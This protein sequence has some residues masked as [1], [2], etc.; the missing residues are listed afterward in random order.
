[1]ADKMNPTV[2]D[3]R[4]Y[5]KVVV[6]TPCLSIGGTEIHTLSLARALI[7]EGCRVTICCYY[8]YDPIMLS[9][10]KAT[11]AEVVLMELKRSDGLLHLSKNLIALFHQIEP[12][13]V[14]IQYI[15]PALTPILAARIAGVK[16]VFATVHSSGS[17]AYGIKAR[18]MLRTAAIFCNAFFCPS[19]DTER[20]WFGNINAADPV[21]AAP[22]S[23]HYTIY[24]PIDT[25][26]ISDIIIKTDTGRLRAL[27]NIFGNPVIGIVG[28]FV[29]QK[30]HTVMLDVMA[31]VLKQI[32]G[33]LL[34]IIGDGP[35]H[36]SLK[37]KAH[38]L[39]I[40][41]NIRWAGCLSQDNL[42]SYYSIMNVVVMPSLYEGFG[43]VAAEAMAAGLP[44][45]GTRVDGLAEVIEDGVTGV[46]VDCGDVHSISKAIIEIV[47]DPKR[48]GAMGSRGRER[49]KRLYS[50]E[51]FATKQVYL[52]HLFDR[53]KE[54]RSH[55]VPDREIRL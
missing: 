27:L 12:D 19:R 16:T 8:E 34:L 35:E 31:E 24:D 15:A 5:E 52:Y 54:I 11:G 40:E 51:T 30:G 25:A 18:I 49:V 45:V 9:Q 46:L 6:C 39:G 41:R 13:I 38:E 48:A 1:M 21:N 10:V 20:F 29:H 17:C 4:Q 44:V 2:T 3:L 32:P 14:H 42:F 43:L 50:Y 28:R 26:R 36:A 55:S 53:K 33:A 37:D 47:R 7:S 23:G 22:G